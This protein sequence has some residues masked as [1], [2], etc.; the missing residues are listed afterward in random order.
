MA[1]HVDILM[2]HSISD[3]DGPTCISPAVFAAQMEALAASGASVISLDQVA[4]WK[5]GRAALPPKP[6]VITF[7]DGFCDFADVAFP[8]LQ[9]HGFG[10]IVYLPTDCMGGL[11][12][13]RG[14][15]EPA[16]PLMSWAAVADLAAEGI[17]FGGHSLT[18]ADLMSLSGAALE[19]EVARCADAIAE[20]TSRP[21]AHFAPPYGR[22][23]AGTLAVVRKHWRTSCG[24]RYARAGRESDL[25][26]LPRLEMFYYTDVKWW[27]A[28]L[29]GYGW[30]YMTARQSL[31][32]V[33]E[34][35]SKPWER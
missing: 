9:Q 23:D 18:H 2:Y 13:W 26:D 8:I 12:N 21:P 6:V 5:E 17:E 35:M 20:H 7:D 34:A 15:N 1:G 33:R 25:H 28:H 27:R 3:G 14:A 11:E 29:A 31:R 19:D 32:A 4:D 16:R 24:T 10:A 22:A 30:P